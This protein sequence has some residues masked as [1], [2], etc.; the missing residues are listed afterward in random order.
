MIRPELIAALQARNAGSLI[1]VRPD[2]TCIVWDLGRPVEVTAEEAAAFA[3]AQKTTAERI[4]QVAEA[5]QRGELVGRWEID[6]AGEL[7]RLDDH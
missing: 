6:D 4:A 7:H 3:D 1:V 2:G 5:A